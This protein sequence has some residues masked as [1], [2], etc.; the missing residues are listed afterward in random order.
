M[1]SATTAAIAQLLKS[2][3]IPLYGCLAAFT[4]VLHD[5]FVTLEDEIRYIWSPHWNLGKML[6]F[7]IRLYTVAVTTFDVIQ[8]HVF[9]KL[10]PSLGVCVAMDPLTRV[11]GAL[12]L[13]SIEIVMQMRVFALYNRSKKVALFN[14]I[15]FLCSVAAF[16]WLLVANA[17]KRSVSISGVKTL[18]IPGCPSIHTGIEYLQ[19]IPA[20]AFE[21]VLFLFALAK[22]CSTVSMRFTNPDAHRVSLYR[23][24]V[25][26]NVLIA[27]VL[28]FNN[29]MVV[30]TTH[31]T[32]FSY[33]P[34]HAA[35][36][37]MTIR[38]L[39]HL[40]KAVYGLS[41]MS[42][43][44]PTVYMA[45]KLSPITFKV[46]HQA[47]SDSG[48]VDMERQALNGR[49]SGSSGFAVEV[50]TSLRADSRISHGGLSPDVF[51]VADVN[52]VVR[53]R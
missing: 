25:Q 35:M 32:W 10:M 45:N 16:L 37:I 27:V 15:L 2:D 3:T 47:E 21:G 42:I 20:T 31:I 18:P 26:D 44:G 29:L 22:T 4:W 53:S 30:A 43:P 17:E 14:G 6:Y 23:L 40:H 38:L 19:W 8:I 33:G 9:S 24:V 46:E 48:S 36:G 7:W 41:H 50:T 34:F 12:S 51:A 28:V 52:V 13:W 49:T 5:Y 39:L 1:P 11:L